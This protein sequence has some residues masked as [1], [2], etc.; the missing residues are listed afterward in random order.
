[1]ESYE[2]GMLHFAIINLVLLH[3]KI[4][5]AWLMQKEGEKLV[6]VNNHPNADSTAL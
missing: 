4:N 1:M 5:L 2:Y 3:L 6:I